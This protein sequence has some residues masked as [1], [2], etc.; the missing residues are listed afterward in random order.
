MIGYHQRRDN[1][2]FI[3]ENKNEVV[4]LS[5]HRNWKYP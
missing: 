4:L 3:S 2:L 1:V 5:A